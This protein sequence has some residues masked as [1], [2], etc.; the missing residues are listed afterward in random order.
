MQSENSMTHLTF[1]INVSLYS[2]NV[3][4]CSLCNFKSQ[5]GILVLYSFIF[6]SFE[7]HHFSDADYT[8]VSV[9]VGF[10]TDLDHEF[11]HPDFSNMLS[12]IFKLDRGINECLIHEIS[13]FL[14][15]SCDPTALYFIS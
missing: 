1:F 13:Y 4:T 3:K 12:R 11:I 10:K 15:A 2:V 8:K 6:F 7:F 5:N 9:T 14:A